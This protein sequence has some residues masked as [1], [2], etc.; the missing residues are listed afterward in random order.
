MCFSAQ[1][2]FIASAALIFISALCFKKAQNN[3]QR[4]LASGPLFFGIQ[5][6]LEG[7]VWITLN[8][9]DTMSALHTCGIHG[10]LSFAYIFWPLYVPFTMYVFE[11]NQ[12]RKKIELGLFVLGCFIATM[13]L[14]TLSLFG[15]TA[16]A[17]H[18]HVV[19][20]YIPSFTTFSASTLTAIQYI[21]LALYALVLVGSMVISTIPYMWLIGCLIAL[22]F[23]VAQILF[24]LAF[25]SV[26]CFFAAVVSMLIYCS[27]SALNKK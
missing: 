11:T 24:T 1:A 4:L 7:L 3:N 9:G 15:Y 13:G 20:Q 19:Y 22:G 23:I 6:F 12:M 18:H 25:G 26:W 27:I 17:I 14:L 2:S 21:L 10:F 16:T 5:Q 8:K